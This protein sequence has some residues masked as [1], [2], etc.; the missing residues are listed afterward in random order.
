MGPI[1]DVKLRVV[2][3]WVG[4]VVVLRS[5]R[6]LL[7]NDERPEKRKEI[8]QHLLLFGL[9]LVIVGVFAVALADVVLFRGRGR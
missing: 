4:D 7:C 3:E 1:V 6:L 9:C 2:D 8:A 5:G